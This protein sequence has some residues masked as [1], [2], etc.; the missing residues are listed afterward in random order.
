VERGG[1]WKFGRASGT[2]E[3]DRLR[4]V[5]TPLE[6]SPRKN[7]RWE[8][9]ELIRRGKEKGSK[10]EVNGKRENL[11]MPNSKSLREEK[12]SQRRKIM[13]VEEEKRT[14]LKLASLQIKM[15]KSP[16]CTRRE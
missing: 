13:E 5:T 3:R 12:K 11:K 10:K 4:R 8:Q 6:I 1:K 7:R 9:L 15:V 16:R 2:G 14:S